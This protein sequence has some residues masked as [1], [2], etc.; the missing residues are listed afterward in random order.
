MKQINERGQRLISISSAMVIVVKRVAHR[1]H[2]VFGLD[3][4]FTDHFIG[5]LQR[6]CQHKRSINRDHI[7]LAEFDQPADAIKL[8]CLSTLI[9]CAYFIVAVIKHPICIPCRN[10]AQDEPFGFDDRH[11][12]LHMI[13]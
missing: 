4:D 10:I 7:I 5:L 13:G 12:F 9:F 3:H 6:D 11:I 2:A 1:D 8:F